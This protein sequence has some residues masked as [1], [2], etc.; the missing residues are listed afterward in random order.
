VDKL[1]VEC[2]LFQGEEFALE[3]LSKMY[4]TQSKPVE[5][6]ET[7]KKMSG[8]ETLIAGKK[9]INFVKNYMP[10]TNLKN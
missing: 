9:G 6:K 4:N 8:I 1:I 2:N 5:Q 10:M 3:V 7:P